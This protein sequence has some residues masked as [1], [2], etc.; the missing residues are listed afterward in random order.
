MLCT[1]LDEKLAML[2]AEVD[3]LQKRATSA[4]DRAA[5]AEDKGMEL[6]AH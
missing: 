5:S 4:E 3:S 2:S 6:P 1:G